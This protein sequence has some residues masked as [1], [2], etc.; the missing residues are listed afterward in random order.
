MALVQPTET[1]RYDRLLVRVCRTT[2]P[3]G[4]RTWTPATS[5]QALA[6][7]GEANIILAT[8]NSQLTFW[9]APA[10]GWIGPVCGYSI[11]MNTSE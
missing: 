10:M 6:E 8:G 2:T 7:R 4:A 9:R 5:S 11:W 1:L 3:W